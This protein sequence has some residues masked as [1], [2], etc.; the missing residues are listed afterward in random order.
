[1]VV[2]THAYLSHPISGLDLVEVQRQAK[3]RAA[4]IA[5][6]R[7]W[8]MV[9]PTEAMACPSCRS[10]VDGDAHRHSWSEWMQVDLEL[11]LACDA[12]VMCEGWM[13][14]PGAKT[15]LTMALAVGKEVYLY[16]DETAGDPPRLINVREGDVIDL[17]Y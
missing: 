15:E 17:D 10:G 13:D 14:S 7:G 4:K 2:T 12:I 5:V 6:H 1:M 9:L 11:L 16:F 3:E 8:K